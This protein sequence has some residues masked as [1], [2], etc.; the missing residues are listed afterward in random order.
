MKNVLDGAAVLLIALSIMSCGTT[1]AAAKGGSDSSAV[2]EAVQAAKIESVALTYN[3]WG[4]G[5]NNQGLVQGLFTESI[6]KDSSYEVNIAG[7][8]DHDIAKLQFVL[9][10]NT[11]P[12]YQ[13]TV[14]SDYVE[15]GTDFNYHWDK[16]SGL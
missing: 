10:A 11:A 12:A 3:N 8:S 6:A 9:I 7:T 14:L 15:L 2:E 13:W 5:E 16:P 1:G 4:S